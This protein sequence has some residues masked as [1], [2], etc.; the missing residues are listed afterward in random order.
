LRLVRDPREE[1]A[2]WGCDLR[3]AARRLWR[4]PSR[5]PALLAAASLAVGIGAACA[6][7]SAVNAV[8][9]RPPSYDHP[10][11][12]VALWETNLRRGR[13][14]D[15]TSP[16]NYRDWAASSRTLEALA[17]WEPSEAALR[18]PASA[19]EPE[20]VPVTR[21]TS[22]LFQTLGARALLGRPLTAEDDDIKARRTAILSH[23]LWIR[24]F[25]GD[26]QILHRRLIIG[27]KPYEVGGVM[28][29]G[30]Q[31]P[32]GVNAD[33]WLAHDFPA[34][35][36][37]VRAVRRYRAVGRLAPGATLEQARAEM[38][39][40]AARLAEEHPSSNDG[41]SVT[42]ARWQDVEW[43]KSRNLL[44]LLGC[45]G[46][47]VLLASLNAASLLLASE[48]S[49]QQEIG[50]RLALGAPRWSLVRDG[51]SAAVVLACA[52]GATGVTLALAVTPWLFRL[53]AGKLA[54]ERDLGPDL[55]VL[56]FSLALTA[57]TALLAAGGPALWRLRGGVRIGGRRPRHLARALLAAQIALTAVLVTGGGLLLRSFLRLWQQDP[58]LRSDGLLVANFNLPSREMNARTAAFYETLLDRL[59]GSPGVIAAAAVTALPMNP[60]EM[61][62]FELPFQVEGDPP[63]VAEASPRLQF[64]AATPGYFA[65]AGIP[66]LAG[67]EFLAADGQR[68]VPRRAIIS[69][70]LARRYFGNRNPL[71]AR[72]QLPFGGWHE[73]VGVVASVRFHGL[74]AEPLP[75]LFVPYRRSPFPGLNVVVR[76]AGDPLSAAPNVR[77]AVREID[78]NI[79]IVRLAAFDELMRRSAAVRRFAVVVVGG[80][81]L[82]GLLLSF[83]GTYALLD[84]DVQRRSRELGVRLALGAPPFRIVRQVLG[85]ALAVTV[86][87]VTL[88]LIA[89][90][91]LTDALSPLLFR[92]RPTDPLT[93]ASVAALVG[94]FAGLGSC[95]PARRAAATD[96]LVILRLER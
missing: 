14:R 36:L 13:L 85:E 45:A 67:R 3:Y 94:L 71:G 41:W 63:V 4:A 34:A 79:P 69:D 9:L 53:D 86:C 48:M 31:F 24:R 5:G 87:G 56:L 93:F 23:R 35:E 62:E 17:I 38:A 8:L 89:A 83:A 54:G 30:F 59:R 18:D 6:V 88:G 27:E 39:A 40:I 91:L 44:V 80:L 57:L 50:V 20:Q 43:E 16:L 64:R 78:P 42:L 2:A 77:A 81:G 12:V 66:L 72:I 15:N 37:R 55:R 84:H 65:T 33:L 28:P 73:I 76:V 92:I 96:P 74:D 52:G 25:G 32:P 82:I 7:F 75:E 90:A 49:R 22:S 26:P 19:A 46:V 61:D 11:R 68:D 70:A 10:E 29:A 47:I 95:Y 21:C 1:L 51:L 58:G 60:T